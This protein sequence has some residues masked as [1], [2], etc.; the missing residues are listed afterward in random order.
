MGKDLQKLAE[1]IYYLPHNADTDRPTLG[2]VSGTHAS[3]IID[4]GNS[5]EHAKLFNEKLKAI[6]FSP[7][8][9]VVNTHWHWDHWFGN[10]FYTVPIIANNYTVDKIK[11]QAKLPWDNDSLD[12]RVRR[13]D[14]IEFCS[15]Y[16]K[17]EFPNPK[18]TLDFK[19]PDTIIE[20]KVEIN[21]GCLT[22][23]LETVDSDHCLQNILVFIPEQSILFMGDA[24]YFNLHATPWNY[25][26]RKL[27]PFLEKVESFNAE[28]II[29]SHS[30]PLSKI[31]YLEY[32]KKLK[33]IGSIV[34]ARGGDYEQI[35]QAL[36]SDNFCFEDD[37]P[38]L[39]KAFMAGL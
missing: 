9:A 17:K 16:I 19:I 34:D 29:P 31:E 22:C 18:R 4:G 28:F 7:L 6:N 5:T 39:I 15:E 33:T 2:F 20:N 21:L 23:V 38:E 26:S 1:S 30:N 37:T 35:I 10:A 27:F 36:K 8:K 13:G 32:F 3:L 12:Q 11:E 24:L 25:T 14:E